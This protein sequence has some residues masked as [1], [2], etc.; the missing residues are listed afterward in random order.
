MIDID[1]APPP[2]VVHPNKRPVEPNNLALSGS[3][4]GAHNFIDTLNFV[5]SYGDL[6][7]AFGTNQQAAQNWYNK[8]EPIEQRVETF[9]GLD[10]VASYSDLIAAFKSAGSKQAVLDA[11]ATHFID[12]GYH[13][14]RT[15]TFNGLDYIASYGDLIN[16][17][18][19]NGDAGAYHYIESGASEG[20]TTTFDGLDYIASYGDLINALGD[21]EQAGARISST[22]DIRKAARRP[23]TGSIISPATAISSRRSAPTTTQARRTTSTMVTT[24]AAQRPSTAWTTSPATAT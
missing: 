15:T 19:A 17:L 1:I 12:A 2:P 5:A 6:I 23:S 11:G 10:Y 18:G 20:R 14:G 21:N 22:T 4:T 13:E 9:D 7:N 24:K 8:Q 3:V 16:A